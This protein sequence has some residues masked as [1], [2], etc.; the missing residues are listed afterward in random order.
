MDAKTLECFKNSVELF[1]NKINTDAY[2]INNLISYIKS[3]NDKSI[4]STFDLN[5]IQT[6]NQAV[7]SQYNKIID[8]IQHI[9]QI[10]GEKPIEIKAHMP[11]ENSVDPS[12]GLIII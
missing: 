2:L 1:N 8:N 5:L 7:L 11:D 4:C 10:G 12:I 6:Q 9:R 3:N